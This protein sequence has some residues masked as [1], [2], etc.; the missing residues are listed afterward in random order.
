MRWLL[1]TLTLFSL[2]LCFT[3]HGAGAMAWWLL[4]GVVG[5]I[6]TTLAFAQA[7]IAG[8]SRNDSLSEYE[9][10]LLR[11]GRLHEG[12]DQLNH[13]RSTSEH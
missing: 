1:L 12:K 2:A 5:A 6:A 4:I 10:R 11:E 3:R 7:K 8:N 13:G 9:L